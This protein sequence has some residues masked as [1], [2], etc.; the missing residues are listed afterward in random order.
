MVVERLEPYTTY[1][2]RVLAFHSMGN[3]ISSQDSVAKTLEGS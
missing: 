3:G 2:L 1:I